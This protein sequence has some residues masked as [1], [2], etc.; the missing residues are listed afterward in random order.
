MLAATYVYSFCL[1]K[2][3]SAIWQ[4]SMLLLLKYYMSVFSKIFLKFFIGYFEKIGFEQPR[5]EQRL[6]KTYEK[7]Q[8]K[9]LRWSA[10]ES[11]L[12]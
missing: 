9:S 6:A 5:T 11:Q 7:L 10:R 4:S 12:M 2:T 3:L 1:L 8:K